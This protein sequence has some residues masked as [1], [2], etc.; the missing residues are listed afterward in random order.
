MSPIKS[1]EELHQFLEEWSYKAPPTWMLEE[2]NWWARKAFQLQ[3]GKPGMETMPAV[4]IRFLTD[5]E[6]AA[7]QQ[8]GGLYI[9][10]WGIIMVEASREAMENYL[11]HELTHWHQQCVKDTMSVLLHEGED[12]YVAEVHEVQARMAQAMHLAQRI[13]INAPMVALAYDATT[14]HV[15]YGARQLRAKTLATQS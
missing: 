13:D 3:T 14:W 11:V 15:W 12:A 10:Q 2:C 7:G 9:P 5:E 6:I 4:F 8:E 1:L